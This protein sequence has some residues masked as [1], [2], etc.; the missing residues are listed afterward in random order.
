MKK[1]IL[2][3][4]ISLL[5]LVGIGAQN[6]ENGELKEY[7][8]NSLA[9]MMVYHSEDTFGIHIHD[10]FQSIP[11]PDKYDNHCIGWNVINNDSVSGAKHRK[12][13]LI[14]A[15][16]GK[17]LSKKD[18]RKNGK[19]L[20]KLMNDAQCGKIM[21]AKWFGM[22]LADSTCNIE[23]GSNMNLIQQRGQYNASDIEDLFTRSVPSE[24]VGI[25]P[26]LIPEEKIEVV[27]TSGYPEADIREDNHAFKR[28]IKNLA[29]RSGDF[30]EK[31][32]I[33]KSLI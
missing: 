13:G 16:Y 14:K 8:R 29:H 7:R 22:D 23:D 10:A 11:I 6:Q 27:K 1:T 4:G 33:F 31:H 20:E 21:V 2:V 5:F 26:M 19:A 15:E 24:G 3:L 30:K 9:T 12:H 28:K 18:V 25:S 32:C 17:P